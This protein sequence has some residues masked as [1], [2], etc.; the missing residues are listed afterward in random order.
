MTKQINMYWR[1]GIPEEKSFNFS[2]ARF[3]NCHDS[4][5]VFQYIRIKVRSF[6][7]LNKHITNIDKIFLKIDSW[8]C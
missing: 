8:L 6:N 2:S 4:H 1:I 5:F 7:L 3:I